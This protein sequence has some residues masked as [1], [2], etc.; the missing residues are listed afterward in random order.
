V[1]V[2][3]RF[4]RLRLRPRTVRRY[5]HVL[6]RMGDTGAAT[7]DDV[8]AY[9]ESATR[10]RPIGTVLPTRAALKHYLVAVLG[11]TP[12]EAHAALPA[13]R[14]RP[15]RLRDALSPEQLATYWTAI[16]TLR[17]GPVRTILA[18][19]PRTGLRV[20]EAC[21]MRRDSV[22]QRGE[23][24]F[25]RFRGKGDK[26]RIV[27]LTPS[28]RALLTDY[29]GLFRPRGDYLFPGNG[30]GPITPE[31]I[32]KTTRRLRTLAPALGDVTPHVLRHTWAT[33]ALG[34]GVDLRTV[35]AALGHASIT[36]TSR[37]LHPTADMLAAAMDRV[38]G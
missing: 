11:F 33:S 2:S 34:A 9:A 13:A 31:A 36:T 15:E 6:T 4:D 16:E 18:L 22:E 30:G 28:A 38:E 19:L 23:R 12:E 8:L 32:R 25:F 10:G 5:D 14:G 37:Y 29:L 21:E 27:P 7:A 1:S 17:P 3:A 26:E 20:S 35:Q 24:L